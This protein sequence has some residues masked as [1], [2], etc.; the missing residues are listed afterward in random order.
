MKYKQFLESRILIITAVAAEK[1]A[2]LR[3]LHGN[4]RFEVLAGGVGPATAAASTAAALADGGYGLVVNAGIGGG[5]AGQADVGSLVVASEI[6]AADLGA[7]TPSGFLNVDELGFGS[8]RIPVNS[9]LAARVVEAFK[10][11]GLT[12]HMGPVLT[13]STVTGTAESAAELTKR[14]PGATAEAMEGYGAA[15][16]AQLHG[17]PILEIR[18]ISNLVGPR[19]RAAWRIEEALHA[20]EAASAILGE[21][22]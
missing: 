6:T 2:I 1:E 20:L 8:S 14:V 13:V 21:V 12:V 4:G 5:F 3:G 22:L 9:D 11:A 7:E 17:I 16:A 18:A 19:D 10:L 15:I